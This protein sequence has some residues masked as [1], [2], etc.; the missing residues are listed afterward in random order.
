MTHYA[1]LSEVATRKTD[2]ERRPLTFRYSDTPIR[3]LIEHLADGGDLDSFLASHSSVKGYHTRVV[4]DTWHNIRPEADTQ[5]DAWRQLRQQADWALLSE[6]VSARI[7]C[8][9]VKLSDPPMRDQY[10]SLVREAAEELG[11]GSGPIGTVEASGRSERPHKKH[12]SERRASSSVSK[13]ATDQLTDAAIC[14]E[15]AIALLA[16]ASHP[17]LSSYARLLVNRV[18]EIVAE[19]RNRPETD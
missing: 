16:R 1:P 5:Q 12:A 18:D 19:V 11:I 7:E 13:R 6:V 9:S 8:E 17:A 4:R 10:L 2:S 15:S 14:L 3:E